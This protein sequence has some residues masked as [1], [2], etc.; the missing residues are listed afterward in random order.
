ME[1]KLLKAN[2]AELHVLQNCLAWHLRVEGEIDSNA[3]HG[4]GS[5]VLLHIGVIPSSEG[6]KVREGRVVVVFSHERRKEE[7]PAK[8]SVQDP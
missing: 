7:K 1:I 8:Q 4:G 3:A 5:L 6:S 2:R